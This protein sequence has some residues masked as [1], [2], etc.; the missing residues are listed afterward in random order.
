MSRADGP[1]CWTIRARVEWLAR[2]DSNQETQNQ[3]LVCYQLHYGPVRERVA[4]GNADATA[5]KPCV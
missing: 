1:A 5:G 4:C 2:L 3:N